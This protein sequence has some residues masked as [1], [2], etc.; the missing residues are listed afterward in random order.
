MNGQTDPTVSGRVRS[1]AA[2]LA[3]R[4]TTTTPTWPDTSGWA[5]GSAP[6]DRPCPTVRAYF[7]SKGQDSG[8]LSPGGGMARHTGLVGTPHGTLA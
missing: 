3:V 8:P 1:G 2:P 7:A 5:R 6:G 4:L